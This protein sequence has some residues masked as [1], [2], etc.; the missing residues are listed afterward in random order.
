MTDVLPGQV[1]VWAEQTVE[2]AQPWADRAMDAIRVLADQGDAFTAEGVR[3]L[4]GDPPDPHA[5]GAV[6]KVAALRGGIERAGFM[7]S[8]RPSSNGR[9][10]A[11][12]RGV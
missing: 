1:P 4:I 6:F 10:L 11:V 12:W 3:A 7:Q 8:N 9:V 2:H 5:M